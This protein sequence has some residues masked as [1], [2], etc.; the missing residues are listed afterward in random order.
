MR[1]PSAQSVPRAPQATP[2]RLESAPY[3]ARTDCTGRVYGARRVRI[4]FWMSLGAVA[5]LWAPAACYPPYTFDEN[6]ATGG[7]T[8]TSGSTGGAGVTSSSAGGGTSVTSSAAGN[9]GGSG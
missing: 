2:V 9:S 7:G 5:A 6:T 3:V 8:S 4:A 1:L